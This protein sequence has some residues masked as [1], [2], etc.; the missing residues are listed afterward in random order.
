MD[1]VVYD[2]E[3]RVVVQFGLI[4]MDRSLSLKIDELGRELRLHVGDGEV[5]H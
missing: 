2:V 5:Q 1:Q 3:T 4:S